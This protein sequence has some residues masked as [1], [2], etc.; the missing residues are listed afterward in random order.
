VLKTSTGPHPFFNHQQTPEE[1]DVAPR[2]S[3]KEETYWNNRWIFEPDVPPAT[4]PIAAKHYRKTQWFGR[5]LFYLHAISTIPMSNQTNSV[6]TLK[7]ANKREYI[8]NM[9]EQPQTHTYTIHRHIQT[10]VR[11]AARYYIPPRLLAA[12]G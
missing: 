6:K 9:L 7:E 3:H 5:H 10:D 12:A 11:T 8:N 4:Q 1:R 2:C